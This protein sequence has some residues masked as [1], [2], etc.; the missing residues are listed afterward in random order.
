MQTIQYTHARLTLPEVL[1]RV[2]PEHL[3]EG[4]CHCG[5]PDMEELRLHCDRY[6]SVHA[7]GKN[8]SIKIC[9]TEKEMQEILKRMCAGSLYAFSQTIN[10][11]YLSL[12]GGIRVGVCGSAALDRGAVIGVSRI[13]G[14]MIRIPHAVEVSPHEILSR[15][16]SRRTRR[17]ILLYAPPGVGKTT[18][19]RA[20]A[21]SA[22]SPTY[23]YRTVVVDT[24]A[25]L[26]YTLH[27][28]DLN[29]DILLG[30]PRDVGIEIAVR[31]MG[32]DLILCDEIGGDADA[33]SI[34]SAA[35]CGV[36]IIASAHASDIEELL[37]RPAMQMLHRAHVF[38][39]YVGLSR[40]GGGLSYRFSPWD[41]F[42]VAH[43]GS[44][45]SER[46]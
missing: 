32:A 11:G 9:L 13:T 27:G 25:E 3:I 46:R 10:R 22:A 7:R 24:R 21:K 41:A 30:Y 31:T 36:P 5:A 34:L 37:S 33:A 14:L 8:Y 15:F 1:G 29:L 35:N 18:L 12:E 43:T 42:S 39:L 19:L 44:Q 23:D 38:D 20:I 28:K 6:A 16:R 2:L 40:E 17:G 4:I 26:S 45:I